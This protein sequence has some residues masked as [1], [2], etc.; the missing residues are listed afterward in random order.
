MTNSFKAI[1][2]PKR[3]QQP[4]QTHSKREDRMYNNKKTFPTQ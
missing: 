3:A 2:K 1:A 4:K